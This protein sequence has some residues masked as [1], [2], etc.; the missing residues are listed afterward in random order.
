MREGEQDPAGGIATRREEEEKGHLRQGV[1]KEDPGPSV[2]GAGDLPSQPDLHPQKLVHP[3]AN[4]IGQRGAITT[5][6]QNPKVSSGE[7]GKRTSGNTVQ[8]LTGKQS[9]STGSAVDETGPSSGC[10]PSRAAEVSA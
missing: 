7:K 4:I 9:E 1:R 6:L 5:G 8:T 2:V 3:L 10:G